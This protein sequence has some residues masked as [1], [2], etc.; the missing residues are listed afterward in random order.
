MVD[1]KLEELL[2]V[3]EDCKEEVAR[4]QRGNRSAATRFRKDLGAAGRLVKELR[5]LALKTVLDA[6][7]EA[8][9]AKAV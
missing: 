3:L 6:K 2:K 5:A 4:V 9:A 7:A 1:S 8:K